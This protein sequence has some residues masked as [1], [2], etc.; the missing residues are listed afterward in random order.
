MALKSYLADNLDNLKR[1]SRKNTSR[2]HHAS[3][4]SAN[5]VQKKIAG[6]LLFECVPHEGF[7]Y[8]SLLD[9]KNIQ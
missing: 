4:K 8:K 7:A 1:Q 6:H 3:Q 5:T 2:I 9:D